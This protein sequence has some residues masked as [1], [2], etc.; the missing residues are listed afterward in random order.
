MRFALV[1]AGLMATVLPGASAGA[2]DVDPERE[3]EAA[4]I[5]AIDAAWSR[6]LHAKDLDTVMANYAEDAVFLAPGQPIIRGRADIRGWF[7]ARISQPD[8]SATFE[9]TSV[10][11]AAARDMA[12]EIG[13]FHAHARDAHGTLVSREGKHLVTWVKQHGRWKVT[14][15]S[16]STDS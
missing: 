3:R 14:A 4:S 9:P 7:A 16:I 8:Y 6:A 1:I 15:E 5:R 13:V 11:V 10:V 2:A 12:Y